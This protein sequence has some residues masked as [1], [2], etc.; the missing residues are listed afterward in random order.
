MSWDSWKQEVRCPCGK[1]VVII[2]T[3]MDDWNRSRVSEEILCEECLRKSELIRTQRLERNSRYSLLLNQ[4]ITYFK[5]K[6]CHIW[7]QHFESIK[8]KKELCNILNLHK[9]ENCT[10]ESFYYKTRTIELSKYLEG[11]IRIE[12]LKKIL[13]LL[14]TD[15]SFLDKIIEEPLLLKKEIDAENLAEYMRRY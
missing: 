9:I 15:D 10:I 3:E 7:I 11:L 1:G 5:G 12:N 4:L 6:Y 8:S 14:G 2:T 13:E